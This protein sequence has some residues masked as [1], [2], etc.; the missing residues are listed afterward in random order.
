M[1]DSPIRTDWVGP[2]AFLLFHDDRTLLVDAIALA[3]RSGWT[4]AAPTTFYAYR[5]SVALDEYQSNPSPAIEFARAPLVGAREL[6]IPEGFTA[7]PGKIGTN[8]VSELVSAWLDQGDYPHEPDHDGSN[9]RGFEVIA[10]NN[11]VAV[12]KRWVEFHK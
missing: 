10:T 7:L 4:T 6:A 9:K 11:G 3:A 12:V 1:T 8:T 2:Y 5:V